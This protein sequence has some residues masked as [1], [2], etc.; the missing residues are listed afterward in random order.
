M[1][2]CPWIN[3]ATKKLHSALSIKQ[4]LLGL[5]LA[6]REYDQAH[7]SHDDDLPVDFPDYSRNTTIIGYNS[8]IRV[9]TTVIDDI[10]RLNYLNSKKIII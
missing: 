8:L 5:G 7:F 2:T 1:N 6:L 9:L 3:P 4:I 10:E